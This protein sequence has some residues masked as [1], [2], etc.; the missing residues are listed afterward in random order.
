MLNLDSH[1]NPTGTLITQPN[2]SPDLL[3]P[4]APTSSLSWPTYASKIALA[5]LSHSKLVM[6]SKPAVLLTDLTSD[7][8]YP[9]VF[10]PHVF[11]PRR[12]VSYAWQN[13]M[14]LCTN[15]SHADKKDFYH[16]YANVSP[17][18]ASPPTYPHHS[19]LLILTTYP[20]ILAM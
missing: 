6:L 2:G 18:R 4:R 9:T 17:N 11:S 7:L 1:H 3:L 12:G 16:S 19:R 10:V 14:P 8:V 15:L 13:R 20:P 5:N